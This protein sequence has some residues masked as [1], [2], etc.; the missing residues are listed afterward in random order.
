MY[1]PR[2][3]EVWGAARYLANGGKPS[4]GLPELREKIPWELLSTK[5]SLM[6]AC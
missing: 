6:A 1:T 5:Q 4:P 3:L 2:H